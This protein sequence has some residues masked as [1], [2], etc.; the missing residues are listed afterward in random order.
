M[1]IEQ[2]KIIRSV[3]SDALANGD[4]FDK[5]QRELSSRLDAKALAPSEPPTADGHMDP[6]TSR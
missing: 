2:A 6:S 3:L 4:D 1:N 5:F